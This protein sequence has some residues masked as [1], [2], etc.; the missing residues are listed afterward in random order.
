M[1]HECYFCVS[2][3]LEKLINK[4]QPDSEIADL[5]IKRVNEQIAEN[6]RSGNVLLSTKIHRLAKYYLEK[7]DLYNEEKRFANSLL[8][9]NYEYWSNRMKTSPDPVLVAAQMAAAANIIDYGANSVPEDIEGQLKLSL[10][11]GFAKDESALLFRR[12]KSAEK[13]LYLGD[14]AGEIVFDKL[15]IETLNHKG[16]TFVVRGK[17]VIN[18]VVMEDAIETGMN[19]VCNVISNGFDAPSTLPEYCSEEFRKEMRSADVVIS[20]G[21]GNFEGLMDS[22]LDKIFYLLIVKCKPVAEI[23]GVNV[24]DMVLTRYK[25][26]E[27]VL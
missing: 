23:L 17:P 8:L 27:H 10:E 14:N 11:S 19:S 15:F 21:Q 12:L 6:Y 26:K 3:T 20:K 9:N 1:R 24:G 18:D 25:S 13:V 5:F 4:F 22:G 2:K 7:E 16:L